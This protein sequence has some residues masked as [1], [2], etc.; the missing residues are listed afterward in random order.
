MRKPS[1]QIILSGVF[2]GLLAAVLL[3]G[4]FL[5]YCRRI[6]ALPSNPDPLLDSMVYMFLHNWRVWLDGALGTLEVSLLGTLIGFLLATLLAFQ[7]TVE[8]GRRDSRP[9]RVLKRAGR[10]LEQGYVAVI[11]GTPMMVQACIIYYGGFAL[12]KSQMQ[13][14]SITEINRAW[15]FFT[16]AL[17]T[18]S[19]N[20]AAYLAEVLRGGIQALERGQ[21]EAAW[22]LGF[23]DWQAMRKI[24]FPQAVRNCL[25]AIG[26]ELINNVKGTSV[27]NII[28]FVEL[29][30]ATGSVAGFYYKYLACYCNAA[31]IYLLMT[32]SL[33]WL[34]NAGM[35]KAGWGV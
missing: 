14:A 25:P 4:K 21:K 11:R 6:A 28:G 26:N 23:T 24:L 10:W 32:F 29:M 16:A 31:L 19:L 18:V 35:K 15:S 22:S 20:S 9:L 27:L 34:L 12:V 8:I 3:W 7:R 30:F 2:P 17:M 5:P 1:H 33:T 13:G